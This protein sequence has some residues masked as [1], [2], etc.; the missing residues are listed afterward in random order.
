[1]LINYM[2]RFEVSKVKCV[3]NSLSF[4]GVILLGSSWPSDLYFNYLDMN[5][6]NIS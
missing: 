1:M 2:V 4:Y 3:L 6:E 5:K